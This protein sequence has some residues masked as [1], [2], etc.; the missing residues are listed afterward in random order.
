MATDGPEELMAVGYAYD[1]FDRSSELRCSGI[2]IGQGFPDAGANN[3]AGGS[4]TAA[5]DYTLDSLGRATRVDEQ[6]GG[7]YTTY[8]YGGGNLLEREMFE[9]DPDDEFGGHLLT[10]QTT[11]A[12]NNQNQLTEVARGP[13]ETVLEP[14]GI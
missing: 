14:V 5:Y 8:N 3:C 11:F 10:E 13:P 2:G 12:Y 6:V 4:P 7:G 9:L 1:R